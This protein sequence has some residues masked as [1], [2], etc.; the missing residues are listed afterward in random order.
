M[1]SKTLFSRFSFSSPLN[2]SDIILYY[3]GMEQC[4]PSH[5]WSGIRDHY[6]IHYVLSGKG[7]FNINGV[8]YELE[9]NQGFFVPPET[10]V[11]YQADELD[12]WQYCWFAFNGIKAQSYLYQIN[13]NINSPVFLY[14]KDAQVQNYIFSM[15]ESKNMS[16]GKNLYLTGLLYML[17]SKIAEVQYTKALTT[18]DDDRKELYVKK[19]VDFIEKNYST[20]MS[21][22]DIAGFIGIDRKYLHSLFKLYL[23]VSPQDFLINYRVNKACELLQNNK[24]SIQSVSHSVGYEDALLF[25][26]IFKKIKGTSPKKFRDCIF[27]I[28]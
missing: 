22:T 18:Q 24:L 5:S 28:M 4:P 10:I 25:S 15:I 17:L 19:S 11:F 8:T 1:D 2:Y 27:P 7:K 20:K 16:Y 9:K 12:P 23:K 3:C 21:I 13:L 6:I 14:D 26:K